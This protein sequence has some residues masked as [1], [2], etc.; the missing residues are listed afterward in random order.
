MAAMITIAC[1]R[2]SSSRRPRPRPRPAARR[3]ARGAPHAVA[4]G[5][6]ARRLA[7]LPASAAAAAGAAGAEAAAV[8]GGA[9]GGAGGAGGAGGGGGVIGGTLS[10]TTEEQA[11][12]T[13]W[14][15]CW[16]RRV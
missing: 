8:A 11:C 1:G 4:R 10:G 2:P 5:C 7:P 14:W 9:G 16:G 12:F 15:S 13:C 6:N 3:E